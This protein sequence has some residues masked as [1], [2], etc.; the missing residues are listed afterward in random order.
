MIY[1]LCVL[2]DVVTLTPL[3]V[4]R[5][6]LASLRCS[7]KKLEDVHQKQKSFATVGGVAPKDLGKIEVSFLYLLNFKLVVS[8]HI[9]DRFLT[10]DFVALR[11]FCDGLDR[12]E[13]D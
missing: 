3:N 8:E 7:T 1:K 5:F 4:Y 11:A 13:V 10:K 9:L 6:I 2:L 12:E